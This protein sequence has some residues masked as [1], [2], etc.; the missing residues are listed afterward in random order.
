MYKPILEEPSYDA[1]NQHSAG[2]AGNNWAEHSVDKLICDILLIFKNLCNTGLR[3]WSAI[4]LNLV[5]ITLYKQV[6]VSDFVNHI[7]RKE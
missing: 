3:A 2:P 7:I 6:I 1:K 5:S 4:C